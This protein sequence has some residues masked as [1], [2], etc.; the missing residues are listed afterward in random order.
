MTEIFANISDEVR[1]A[2]EN[3]WNIAIAQPNPVEVANFLNN[4][5]N[6]YKNT[7]TEEEIEFLQFYFH[8]RMEMMK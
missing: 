5:T 6:Y 8:T 1:K 2:A 7:F 3:A 4:A